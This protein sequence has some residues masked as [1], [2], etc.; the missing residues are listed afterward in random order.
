[1]AYGLTTEKSASNFDVGAGEFSFRNFDPDVNPHNTFISLGNCS[2][3]T[4]TWTVN[5]IE[6]RDA[7]RGTKRL[8]AKAE[9]QRDASL[10]ITMD[11]SDPIKYAL[12]FYGQTA[13]KE[14]KEEDILAQV[15]TVSPG[16]EVFIMTADG[17]TAAYNYENLKVEYIYQPSASIAQP[18]LSMQGGVTLSTGAIS[19]SGSYVGL[20]DED[21]YVKI[22]KA[23]AVSG[24]ITDAEFAWKKGLASSYGTPVPVTG[25]SQIVDN[26][27]LVT[28]TPG[29]SGQDFVV[30][31]EWKIVVKAGGK[32]LVQGKDY[33]MDAV[34]VR[35]GK[36]R[37]PA[38]SSIGFDTKLKLSCHVPHQFIPRIYAGVQKQI[39]GELRFEYDPKYG[40]QKAFTFYHVSISPSGDDSLIT[41]EWGSRQLTAAVMADYTRADPDNP[42]SVYYRIDHPGS[43]VGIMAQRR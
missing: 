3:A 1:M 23:N 29:T 27:L 8:I 5:S 35:N 39:E 2:A 24:V 21:Y 43:T 13:I 40:R 25:T 26:G 12:A 37:F 28:F 19:S 36:V 14:I 41:E 10:S 30:G 18:V 42:D 16:D 38:D 11:E 6:K 7:T 22:T 4:C 34:D 17:S 9:T 31:D 20:T 33:A 32:P 15:I